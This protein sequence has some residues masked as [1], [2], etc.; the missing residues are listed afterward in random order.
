MS[1]NRRDFLKYTGYLG[2]ATAAG[3]IPENSATAE[4]PSK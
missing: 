3:S 2:A 1:T 4:E